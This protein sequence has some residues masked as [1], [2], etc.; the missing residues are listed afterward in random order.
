[1]GACVLA[2]YD[3]ERAEHSRKMAESDWHFAVAA[4]PC[5]RDA[6]NPCGI[7]MA[8][9]AILA[10]VELWKLT[11]DPQYRDEA[12]TLAP[13]LVDSQQKTLMPWKRPLTGFF[14]TSPKKDQ[15]L[16]YFHRGHEQ[17]PIVA[18]ARLC[19]EFPG[20]AHWMDWYSTVVLHS[21]YLKAIASYAEPYRYLPA[22]IYRE[23]EADQAPENSR[24]SFRT[25]VRN[26]IPLGG[27]YYLRHF[28]VWFDFRGNYGVV[29][30]Q[31]LALATAAVLRDDRSAAG[32]AEEQLQWVV[33]RNP[34][35]QSTMYGEG[36]LFCSLY[37]AM[38]GQI[39]GA[40]PVGIETRG[41]RDVPYWPTS[42]Y[43]NWKEVWVHP[44][45]R[46]MAIVNNLESLSVRPSPSDI[47]LAAE[48]RGDD[49]LL[50]HASSS[51]GRKVD[52]RAWNLEI[53]PT[54]RAS[55]YTARIV[56]SAMPWIVVAAPDG[57]FQLRK[58][59]AGGFH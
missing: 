58:E 34:F 40:L 9:E 10:S 33:G 35:V 37:N 25:Q 51:T 50:I 32:L 54:S 31:T 8:S 21:E 41:D 23:E 44:V 59:I 29:L 36:R 16:H 57:Q 5:A 6:A 38:S 30:S 42:N 17:A 47:S 24:Q 28:P 20:D 7:V 53:T 46:W 12:F 49:T 27:G 3:A 13:T 45:A 52:L 18:L 56:S 55:E 2:P 11:G 19:E 1:M 15:I 4:L 48:R 22:S 43:P 39:S 14:Y 26:G